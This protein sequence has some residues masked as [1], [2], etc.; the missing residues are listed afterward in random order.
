[1]KPAFFLIAGSMLAC[2]GVPAVA[3]STATSQAH[4]AELDKKFGVAPA[5]TWWDDLGRL[6]R[7]NT[8]NGKKVRNCD[9]PATPGDA[10]QAELARKFG[11]APQGQWWDDMGRLCRINNDAAKTRRCEKPGTIS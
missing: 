9:R 4:Q 3:Q 6:C 5:G 7:T 10:H 2:A 11:P 8:V 1:M